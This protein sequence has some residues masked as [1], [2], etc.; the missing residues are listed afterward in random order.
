MVTATE[1][2]REYLTLLWAGVPEPRARIEAVKK[3]SFGTHR[4]PLGY[5]EFEV[6]LGGWTT[7]DLGGKLG[8]QKRVPTSI[9]VTVRKP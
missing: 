6:D 9:E 8:V 5:T 2:Q 4:M 1:F 7:V 3:I